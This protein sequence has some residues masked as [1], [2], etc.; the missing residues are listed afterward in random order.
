MAIQS[1]LSSPNGAKRWSRRVRSRRRLDWRRNGVPIASERWWQLTM[2]SRGWNE[3]ETKQTGSKQC[4]RVKNGSKRARSSRAGVCEGPVRRQRVSISLIEQSQRHKLRAGD[5]KGRS[6]E[7]SLESARNGR[8]GDHE[9][10]TDRR[11]DHVSCP[12]G[13]IFGRGGRCERWSGGAAAEGR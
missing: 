10:R 2:E 12:M 1:R 9:G 8:A 6:G 3:S 5:W 11:E 7:Y 13:G 4:S